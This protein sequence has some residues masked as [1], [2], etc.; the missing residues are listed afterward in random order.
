M[1]REPPLLVAVPLEERKVGDPQKG[2]L[3]R[4][5]QVL[6][7][8]EHEPKLSEQL[9]DVLSRASSKQQEVVGRGA[10]PLEGAPQG[11]LRQ[12]LHRADGGLAWTDPDQSAE[13]ELLCLL[14]KQIDLAARVLVATRDGKSADDPALG[15]N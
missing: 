2:K 15:H 8:R 5:Q 11:A 4:V 1:H 12:R 14:D 3:L 7:F 6:P 10:A 13:S 9:R